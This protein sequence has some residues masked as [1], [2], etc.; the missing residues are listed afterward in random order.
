MT[1]FEKEKSEQGTANILARKSIVSEMVKKYVIHFSDFW[2]LHVFY[3]YFQYFSCHYLNWWRLK[4]FIKLSLFWYKAIYS[5]VLGFFKF[6]ATKKSY[7]D[8][9]ILVDYVTPFEINFFILTI[10]CTVLK[11]NYKLVSNSAFP[12]TLNNFCF[13]MKFNCQVNNSFSYWMSP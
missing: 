4:Q 1:N 9:P 6:I 11:Q 8:W 2:Y 10:G 12:P 3:Q 7:G 13:S 5:W